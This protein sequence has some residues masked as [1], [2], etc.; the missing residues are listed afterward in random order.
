MTEFG[1]YHREIFSAAR[2]LQLLDSYCGYLIWIQNAAELQRNGCIG[3]V[4]E[5]GEP[6]F[7]AVIAAIWNAIAVL[8][9]F[10]LIMAETEIAT[11]IVF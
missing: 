7:H 1:N 10:G 9:R 8:E 4:F 6:R 3:K 11:E 5:L 2:D